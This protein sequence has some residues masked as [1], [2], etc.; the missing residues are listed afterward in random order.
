MHPQNTQKEI[1]TRHHY[2]MLLKSM[3]G[4]TC[5]GRWFAFSVIVTI[6]LRLLFSNVRVS[7][8]LTWV[9]LFYSQYKYKPI[10]MYFT[11]RVILKV[12]FL[13]V[14]KTWHI[15]HRKC[16]LPQLCLYSGQLL[17]QEIH[18]MYY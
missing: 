18:F 7:S 11:C 2:G 15:K 14:C 16:R 3:L 5:C 9:R 13:F 6:K 4:G 8:V 1:V 17:K 12:A 10:N